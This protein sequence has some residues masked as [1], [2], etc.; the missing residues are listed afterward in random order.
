LAGGGAD[1]A[2]HRAGA[3]PRGQ[4]L[5]GFQVTHRSSGEGVMHRVI[6]FLI[7]LKLFDIYCHPHTTYEDSAT[8]EQKHE[9]CCL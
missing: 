8:V 5:Q 3:K 7:L 2:L 4:R 6:I 9:L 1:K